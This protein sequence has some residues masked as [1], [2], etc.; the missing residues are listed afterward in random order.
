MSCMTDNA[1]I[2]FQSLLLR[3]GAELDDLDPDLFGYEQRNVFRAAE[4]T[5]KD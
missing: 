5:N 4:R 1:A 2:T 3:N